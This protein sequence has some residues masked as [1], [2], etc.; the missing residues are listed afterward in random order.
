MGEDLFGFRLSYNRDKGALPTNIT[1]LYNG[2]IAKQEWQTQQSK[3]SYSEIN[4]YNYYYDPLNRLIDANYYYNGGH[5]RKYTETF[6][7][8]KNGNI[9]QLKG[10]IITLQRMP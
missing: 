9:T 2:N 4:A 6:S 1:P 8:D 5:T 7:Y 10:G 3:G